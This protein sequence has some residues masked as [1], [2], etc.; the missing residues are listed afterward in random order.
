MGEKRKLSETSREA[1][2]MAKYEFMNLFSAKRDEKTCD[3]TQKL[4]IKVHHPEKSARALVRN[5]RSPSDGKFIAA[6][7]FY[8]RQLRMMKKGETF[9]QSLAVLT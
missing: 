6:M 2:E 9:S 3:T 1:E 5:V 8:S 4:T 7:V